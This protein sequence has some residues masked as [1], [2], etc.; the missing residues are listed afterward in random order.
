MPSATL[1]RAAIIQWKALPSGDTDLDQEAVM[2]S[3]AFD[4]SETDAN[5]KLQLLIGWV[6]EMS[7]SG[8]GKAGDYL[9]KM[10]EGTLTIEIVNRTTIERPE[11]KV[12]KSAEQERLIKGFTDAITAAIGGPPKK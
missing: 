7:A 11:I 9:T 8:K 1:I 3:G 12:D 2:R 4:L 6:E 10:K 5:I